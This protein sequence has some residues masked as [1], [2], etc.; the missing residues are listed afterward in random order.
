MARSH[1]TRFAPALKLLLASFGLAPAALAAPVSLSLEDAVAPRPAELMSVAWT[2]GSAAWLLV[3]GEATWLRQTADGG[4]RWS[5]IALERGA[6]RPLGAVGAAPVFSSAKVGVVAA[7]EHTWVTT[8]GGKAWKDAFPAYLS[9]GSAEGLLWV[10]VPVD[11]EHW[12]SRVSEDG[13]R[14]W[15]DCGPRVDAAQGRPGASELRAGGAGWM[16]GAGGA[17]PSAVW[18]TF[19]GGCNWIREGEAPAGSW[20][21]ITGLDDKHA[22]LL[23]GRG[24]LVATADGARTWTPIPAPEAAA[25]FFSSMREGWLIA[26]DG[27]LH[28]S[29]DGG[30]TWAALSRDAATKALGSPALS[31]W[32]AGRALS[33]M[34]A[35]G[36]PYPG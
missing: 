16:V 28:Q 9:A 25:V 6:Q 10:A 12:Q 27:G 5:Q 36:A 31:S 14:T 23:S 24:E 2:D 3:R 7:G 32:S 1:L 29:A 19:D 8:N 15:L 17:G 13:G 20:K 11:A 30:A 35:G 26:P 4:K 21:S 33:L 34:L 22:W 18:T